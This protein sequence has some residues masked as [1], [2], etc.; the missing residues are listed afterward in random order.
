MANRDEV[1]QIMEIIKGVELKKVFRALN[2]NT[3]G[4]G[5][6]LRIL[7]DHGKT[8]TSGQISDLL[9]VSSARVAVLLKTMESKGLIAKRKD[10]L[11]GRITIVTLTPF[12]EEAISKIHE[13][14]YN[15]ISRIIDKV[16]FDRLKQFITLS[17]EIEKA[18]KPNPCVLIKPMTN[19]KR[20]KSG[21]LQEEKPC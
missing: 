18:I 15:Q 14:L 16:G 12:G 3:A 2:E 21:I 17:Q 8:V 19:E 20:Y 9:G 7:Y 4:I 13:E 5:A 11:D 10:V 6:V 1:E